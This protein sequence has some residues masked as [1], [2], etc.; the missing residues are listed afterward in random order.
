MTEPVDDPT[1][2]AKDLEKHAAAA[3]LYPL[4]QVRFEAAGLF[5][6]A[7]DDLLADYGAPHPLP[8]MAAE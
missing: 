1:V 5:V 7:L 6:G 2:K 3:N 4:M 8:A